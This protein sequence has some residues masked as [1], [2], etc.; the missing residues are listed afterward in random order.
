MMYQL[1]YISYLGLK[2]SST[3]CSSSSYDIHSAG[4]TKQIKLVFKSDLSLF[5]KS[6]FFQI[7]QTGKPQIPIKQ[8]V[9]HP[10]GMPNYIDG[11]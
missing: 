2:W 11:G 4:L 9:V 7:S 8:C 3:K 6:N 5:A 1:Y 10:V